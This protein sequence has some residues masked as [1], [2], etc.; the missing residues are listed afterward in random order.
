[1]GCGYFVKSKRS[2]SCQPIKWH[3]TNNALPQEHRRGA[4]LAKIV[5]AYLGHDEAGY[6]KK[7]VDADTSHRPRNDGRG[8]ARVILSDVQDSVVR[9]DKPSGYRAKRLQK[10]NFHGHL[11]VNK[12][13]GSLG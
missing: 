13:C 6:Y 3:D 9:N 11:Q 2:Y 10:M 12:Q 4:A 5:P 1:M 8:I 7:D